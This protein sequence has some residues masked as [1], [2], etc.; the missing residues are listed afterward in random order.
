MLFVILYLPILLLA[1]IVDFDEID[2]L[3]EKAKSLRIVEDQTES[4]E[5]I[6][7][8]VKKSFIKEAG[9][10]CDAA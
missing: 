8:D 3:L 1:E 9:G 10:M 6:Q 5:C 4:T 2:R 7:P